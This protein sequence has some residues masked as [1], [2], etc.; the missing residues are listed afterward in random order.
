MKEIW[1]REHKGRLAQV[2]YH[3][4]KHKFFLDTR[5]LVEYDKINNI[6]LSD[7]GERYALNVTH[8][9]EEFIYLDGIEGP[10]YKEVSN[11][12]FSPDGKHFA[13][14][15]TND[16]D[17]RFA[18][19]DGKEGKAYEGTTDFLYSSDGRLSYRVMI[20]GYWCMVIDDKE[21]AGL[22]DWVSPCVFG[23]NGHYAYKVRNGDKWCV[24]LDGIEGRWYKTE[25]SGIH[26]RKILHLIHSYKE[27]EEDTFKCFVK[28]D[29]LG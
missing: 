14:F 7:N 22:Y 3:K 19:I 2:F 23:P 8:N 25:I 11:M 27:N 4:G 17:M 18:V 5:K 6:L 26:F 21:M 10:H 29:I 13:Y 20:H 28:D 1:R 12:T 24:V 9:G 15:A 16:D